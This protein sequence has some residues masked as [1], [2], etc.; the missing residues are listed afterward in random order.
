M[1]QAISS[2]S[3]GEIIEKKNNQG[4]VWS[5]YKYEYV[6]TGVKGDEIARLDSERGARLLDSIK[7][8]KT[9]FIAIGNVVK[10]KRYIDT[11]RREKIVLYEDLALK[12]Q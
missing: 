8:S 6:V 9:E 11:V 3:D 7:D 10:N 12:D 4:V 1:T 5:R 2:P